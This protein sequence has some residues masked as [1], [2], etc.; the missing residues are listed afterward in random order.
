MLKLQEM[1]EQP[2]VHLLALGGSLLEDQLAIIGDRTDCLHEMQ[3][4]VILSEGIELTDI[5]RFFVGNKPAQNFERGTQN[6]GNYKCGT[7]GIISSLIEV[8]GHA[9][10]CAYRSLDD[11]QK[12]VIAGTYGKQPR[13]CKPFDKLKMKE[14]QQELR[15]RFITDIDGLLADDLRHT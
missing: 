13:V 11:L 4:K 8:Q 6:G 1:I 3:T 5:V 9:L 2:Q 15:A 10:R 7:C 12:L 14:L